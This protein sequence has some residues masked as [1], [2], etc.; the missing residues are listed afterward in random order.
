MQIHA[1]VATGKLTTSGER[2]EQARTAGKI[3]WGG[4]A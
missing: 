4:Q 3:G 1:N 2:P